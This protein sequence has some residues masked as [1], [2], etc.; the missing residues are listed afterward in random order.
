LITT[1]GVP[2][3][4]DDGKWSPEFKNF[5]RKCL[6]K[7]PEKRPEAADLLKVKYINEYFFF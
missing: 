6:D 3:L 5:V 2:E 1:K 7:E 4:K